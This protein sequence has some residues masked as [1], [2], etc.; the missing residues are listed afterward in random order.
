MITITLYLTKVVSLLLVVLSKLQTKL[1]SVLDEMRMHELE[2]KAKQQNLSITLEF[3]PHAV[4]PKTGKQALLTF[5]N[6][7]GISVLNGTMFYCSNADEY[8]L[9]ILH[10]GSLTYSTPIT[11]DV[12]G[13]LSMSE[14]IHYAR[15]VAALPKDH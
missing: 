6:G 1:E 12:L 11:N 13:H 9:A 4:F 8:E 7:Y 5:D 3:V 10:N 2:L 15:L 14:V